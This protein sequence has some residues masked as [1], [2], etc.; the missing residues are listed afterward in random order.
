[1]I[2]NMENSI[3]KKADTDINRRQ[4]LKTGLALAGGALLASAAGSQTTRKGNAASINSFLIFS[5]V[6]IFV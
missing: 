2:S 5:S 4:L 6:N 1:M 3:N